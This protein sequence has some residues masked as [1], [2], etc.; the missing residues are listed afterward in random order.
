[1]HTDPSN[2]PTHTSRVPGL[3]KW[4][5]LSIATR[6]TLAFAAVSVVAALVGALALGAFARLRDN[7]NT[8]YGDFTV[9]ATNLSSA[10]SDLAR[11]RNNVFVGMVASNED[12]FL[13]VAK[14]QPGLQQGIHEHLDQYGAHRTF[15]TSSR[16]LV[17][18]DYYDRYR[19][20]LDDYFKAS[21]LTLQM[22][23]AVWKAGD[24]EAAGLARRRAQVNDQ[25][26]AGPKLMEAFTSYDSLL[27]TVNQL[28]ADADRSGRGVASRGS[29]ALIVGTILAVLL[30]I[31]FGR[32]MALA[33]ARPLQEAGRMLD[34]VARGDFSQNIRARSDDEVG[35]MIRSLDSAVAS[36]RMAFGEVRTVAAQL[37]GASKRLTAGAGTIATGAD[38]ASG[39][40]EATAASLAEVTTAAEQ[41]AHN[42]EEAKQFASQ[43]Q[44]V[45]EKGGGVVGSA[46]NAMSEINGSSRR[47]ADI[48]GT[49]DEIAFQTNLLALNAAVEAARAGEQGRGFAVVASEVR[50]LAQRSAGAAREIKA[51]ITDSVRKVESG[52]ALVNQSGAT[53][54]EI[55]RSAAHV[56]EIVAQIAGASREQSSGL[57]Q[58]QSAISRLDL[59][60]QHN[61]RET[62]QLHSTAGELAEQAEILDALVGRFR[63]DEQ[64]PPLRAA[65]KEAGGLFN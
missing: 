61:Q 39:H 34:Q 7:L 51:L 15:R 46:V 25:Y 19:A 4:N 43:S 2:A 14:Q 11:Y 16:G 33:V 41:T 64:S 59:V 58:I 36:V 44:Q 5:N 52:S 38:E 9:G 45:A 63:L 40:L 53:L 10:A 42:A 49:I 50:S 35:V 47:I 32:F 30:S 56:R 31:L 65:A 62:S 48:I 24:E 13:E 20:A 1:M 54:E 60:V 26:N 57:Q 17:E 27:E 55:L 29:Q 3:A 28:G 21:N 18:K 6:L 37:T 8:M 23:A 22:E 12:A